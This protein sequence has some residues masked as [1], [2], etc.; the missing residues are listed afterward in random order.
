M[1]FVTLQLAC[2]FLDRDMVIVTI[3]AMGQN[4]WVV[5]PSYLV[6]SEWM[7]T[8]GIMFFSIASWNKGGGG[9]SI[10]RNRNGD[11]EAFESKQISDYVEFAG[12][13]DIPRSMSN[14]DL[15]FGL[16][17]DGTRTCCVSSLNSP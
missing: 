10:A 11:T 3:I 9:K 16:E 5:F 6:S 7:V 13:L 4:T 12:K 14:I 8:C 17:S 2:E 1:A 15:S